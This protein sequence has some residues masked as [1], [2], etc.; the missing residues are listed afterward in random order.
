[1]ENEDLIER[2][3]REAGCRWDD[4]TNP[5]A[6]AIL[7][8]SVARA[9][10]QHQHRPAD[11]VAVG[12]LIMHQLTPEYA[13]QHQRDELMTQMLLGGVAPDDIL[14]LFGRSPKNEDSGA[15]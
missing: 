14:A 2:A 3:E 6:L 13:A 7:F 15:S 10:G 4:P 9:L 8:S 12:T 11:D 1:M 5:N